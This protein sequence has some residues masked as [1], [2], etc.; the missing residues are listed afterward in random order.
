LVVI[1]LLKGESFISLQQRRKGGEVKPF[2]NM[3]LSELTVALERESNNAELLMFLSKQL[4][5]LQIDNDKLS[6]II[7]DMKSR[8]LKT[9][10]IVQIEARNW[11]I[12]L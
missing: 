7:A 12:K 5:E 11:G 3:T 6:L 1:K 9:S 8:A 10:T 2:F 4:E